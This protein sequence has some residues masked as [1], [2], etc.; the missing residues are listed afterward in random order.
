MENIVAHGVSNTLLLCEFQ[1][2]NTSVLVLAISPEVLNAT[3]QGSS[4]NCKAADAAVAA[5]VS[6]D[7]RVSLAA[8]A[9]SACV[10]VILL[11]D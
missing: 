3:A 8:A 10:E 11:A 9:K 6:P 1:C 4:L 7:L 2:S 5:S